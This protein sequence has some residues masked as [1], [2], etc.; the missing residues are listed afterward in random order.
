MNMITIYS[1][2]NLVTHYVNT[3]DYYILPKDEQISAIPSDIQN[4][5]IYFYGNAL[6]RVHL[7]PS[8]SELKSLLIGN[9]CFN[10]SCD[11]VLDG[12][13]SLEN[14]KIGV[15]CLGAGKNDGVN[16]VCR[17]TNCPHLKQ[18]EIFDGSLE[19]FKSFEISNVNSIQSINFG[20]CCFE[21]A[22]LSLK[23]E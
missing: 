18:L 16:G 15:D 3:K 23:G 22:D 7:S 9:N 21:Y 17:I 2:F 5:A 10:K 6:R 14:V 19:Y 4:L 20:K 12:L 13:P 11:F 1:S 8:L